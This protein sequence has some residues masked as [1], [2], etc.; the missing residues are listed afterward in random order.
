MARA[1]FFAGNSQMTF[2]AH[3]DHVKAI[4][5]TSHIGIGPQSIGMI[6][7][8]PEHM[9]EVFGSMMEKACDVWPDH[10]LVLEYLEDDSDEVDT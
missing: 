8:S 5:D 2:E 6:F 4:I 7:V 9:L 1:P 3:A 10:P